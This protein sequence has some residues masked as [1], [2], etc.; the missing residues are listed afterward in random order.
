[1]PRLIKYN[2]EG[3][4]DDVPDDALALLEHTALWIYV[5]RNFSG[6][7]RFYAFAT[8]GF[9]WEIYIDRLKKQKV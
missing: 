8:I 4:I 1:M 7:N 5:N 2:T 6:E 9:V 3:F